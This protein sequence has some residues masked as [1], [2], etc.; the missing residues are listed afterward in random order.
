MIYAVLSDIH[1]NYPAFKAAVDDAKAKGAKA[2]LLLGDYIRDTPTLNEVV[3]TMRSLPNLTAILGNG[4]SGVLAFDK[5]R[6]EFCEYEQMLPSF[7]TFKNLSEENLEYLKSLPKTATLTLSCGKSLH[8]SH[9]ISLIDHS[10]RLSCFRSGDYARRMEKAPFT[11][12]EGMKAMQKAAEEYAHEISEYPGDICLFGHNHL[13]FF[14]KVGEKLLLNPGSCGMPADYDTRAPYALIEDTQDSV[15]LRLCRAEYDVE[16]AF[17][18]VLAFDGF[19]CA[20]FWGKLRAAILKT[21][22]DIPMSRFLQHVKNIGGD[23]FPLENDTWRKA[24]ATFDFD[25]TWNTEDWRRFGER[26][27]LMQHYNALVDENNDP[28]RDPEPV[29]EYMSKWDGE[30]FLE[31]MNLDES[32]SVLE[33]GVGTGR[34]ALRV[35]SRC[36][37]FTGIDI[38]SK[39]VE[40]AKENLSGFSNVRLLCGDYLTYPFSE[41]F[42]VVY[43]SLTF[44]H[45]EDKKF[46]VEKT[47]ELLN[48]GGR[49]LLSIDKNRQTEIDFGTRRIRVYPDIPETTEALLADAGFEIESRW[50]TEFAFIFS[51]A[52]KIKINKS[53]N[54]L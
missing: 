19:P 44:M 32:K 50:E 33:I 45:I 52:K 23:V 42:D 41:T 46:A 54:P 8:M 15:E 1:G 31:A 28:A 11:W 26:M 5:T 18:A 10:P 4:D 9:S 20:S 14:G 25:Y 35:I 53:K 38:S 13:P 7:W 24:I 16:E 6:P 12:E 39:T 29:K 2:F 3:D 48:L 30:A 43:S 27:D 21:G 51:A 34:L 22:S 37:S 36:R 40:R 17:R 49:F 47:Y